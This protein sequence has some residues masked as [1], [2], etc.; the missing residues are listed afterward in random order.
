MLHQIEKRQPVKGSDNVLEEVLA[1]HQKNIGVLSLEA[2]EAVLNHHDL[3]KM[4]TPGVAELSL[5]IAQNHELAREWTISGKLIAVIT[6]GS[7]VLG[8]GNMGTQ[9]GLPIVEG[10][11]LLYKNLAGVDAI[12]LAL[13]QKSVDE[14]VQTIENLQNSFAGIH[15]E[16]ISAPKCFEIEEKLQQRLNIPV[17]HDDQEGTAIV[18]L[19]GL[20][21]AAKIKGKPLNELRVVINGVGASGVATAKLC[22]QAGI[23]HLTLV[24]RQGVLREED[25][26][27]NPYQRALLRQVIKPSVENKD[28][29]TAV[30]NQDVFLGLSEADVLTPALIKSMNQDPIIF[31]LANPKPEIEPALAQANGVR[32]LA[33]G[34]SKYPNQVN[35]ILAFPGLFKGLLAAKGRKVDVGLQ[36][37]VARSLAAMISE[38]TAEKFIPNVFDGGV[39]DTVFNAV[40][41]YIKQEKTMAEE[42][43]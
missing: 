21:N 9:A 25:P 24:D 32:L 19:A 20:I 4:Y 13:E 43:T 6:D 39:V 29:A 27:L 10:K 26:T 8:L 5:M 7:A 16:D 33:T 11:A 35:N 37:T 1:I 38:P 40:L 28:L 2:T 22:I 30:V 3:A 41:D 14:M 17:Y 34:S 23:T 36:M 12:P 42:G 15:L 18:V 31:A